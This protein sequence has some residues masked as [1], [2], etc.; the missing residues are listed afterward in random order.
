MIFTK[1]ITIESFCSLFHCELND[2]PDNFESDFQ[3]LNTN[4]RAASKSDVEKYVLELLRR[5]NLPYRKTA[6]DNLTVWEKGW[7]EN[8]ETFEKNFSE[9]SL[10]PKY[11]RPHRFFRYNKTII[12]PENQNIEYDLF[13]M[14]RYYLFNRYLSR[15][16]NIYELGCGSCQNLFMLAKLFSDKRIIGLDWAGASK[17]IADLIRKKYYTNVDA[18]IFNMIEPSL[19]FELKDCSVVFSIHSLEQLGKNY[20]KLLS[21]LLKQKPTM[22]IHYEPIIEL[23]DEDN[24]YDFLAIFYSKKR[25]YLSNYLNRLRVLA[26]KGRIELIEE[27]RPYIG[28]IYHEA[29][30]IIWRPL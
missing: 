6:E 4:Y 15:F 1:K 24:L 30:L 25:K 7:S 28:G 12:M 11:F 14:A 21:F 19:E 13:V 22:V 8:L 9:E 26:Q 3:S 10:K 16:K 20:N 23:Y 5:A 27:L 2:L 17:K 29:S 18:Y